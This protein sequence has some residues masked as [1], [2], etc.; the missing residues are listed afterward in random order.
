MNSEQRWLEYQNKAEKKIA[1]LEK[2]RTITDSVIGD[3]FK[4]I[5]ELESKLAQKAKEDTQEF[6]LKVRDFEG[7]IEELE[8]QLKESDKQRRKNLKQTNE[9]ANEY[10]KMRDKLD[11]ANRQLEKAREIITHMNRR[12]EE[13]KPIYIDGV[14]HKTIKEF[15]NE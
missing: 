4:K 9:Y 14:F 1:Q 3:N 11:A 12:T 10:A 2:L 15:I 7:K 6:Y 5:A 13:G 8:K